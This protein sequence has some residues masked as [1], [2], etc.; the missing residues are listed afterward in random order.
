MS[1][2]LQNVKYGPK[3]LETNW[4]NNIFHSHDLFCGCDNPLKHLI[5]ILNKQ[6]KAPKPESEAKNILC[7]ITGEGD[8]TD[9]EEEPF[10]DGELERLFAEDPSGDEKEPTEDANG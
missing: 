7:L 3:Q 1:K 8:S 6:G 9:P 4:V 2:Q 5:I 10:G